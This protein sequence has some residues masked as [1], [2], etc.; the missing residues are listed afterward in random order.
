VKLISINKKTH[1]QK[2]YEKKIEASILEEN[3]QIICHDKKI[4][5]LGLSKEFLRKKLINFK[6][7][8]GKHAVW[9]GRITKNFR[10]Y[11]TGQKIY[12]RSNK[13]ICI[14]TS[15]QKKKDWHEFIK[16]NENIKTYSKLIRVGV[17]YY[18]QHHFGLSFIESNMDN[19][20]SSNISF[21]VKESLTAIKGFSELLL[22]EYRDELSNQ[23]VNTIE[24][25]YEQCLLLESKIS[26]KISNSQGGRNFDVLLIEDGP[27]TTRIIEAICKKKGY[28]FKIATTGQRGLDK[29]KESIPK[30]ILLDIMLPDIDGY[31]VCKRIKANN[32]LKHIPVF[33]VSAIA[34][35]V[36]RNKIEETGADGYI[37]KPFGFSAISELLESIV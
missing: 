1:S 28:S 21:I 10:Q 11:L 8:T 6:K 2:I 32:N 9:L 30:L 33:Y 23:V 3:L 35:K 36:I 29:L 22:K 17:D 7:E 5:K 19:K 26:S 31:E 25:I 27:P 13:R 20:D 4:I 18:V 14:Y 15:S 37:L 24:N 12:G 34:E 16:N